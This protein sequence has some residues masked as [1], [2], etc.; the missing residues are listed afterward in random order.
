MLL[1]LYKTLKYL[2]N[3]GLYYAVAAALLRKYNNK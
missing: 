1:S 3:G 2:F